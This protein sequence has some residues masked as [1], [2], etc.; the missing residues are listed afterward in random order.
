MKNTANKKSRPGSIGNGFS[1]NQN[2][3]A[4]GDIKGFDANYIAINEEKL[5]QQLFDH[6]A[7]HKKVRRLARCLGCNKPKSPLKFSIHSA[8]CRDCVKDLQMKGAVARSNFIERAKANVGR[9]L[10]GVANYA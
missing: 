7:Q 8:I 1:S 5:Q 4:D 3:Y 2:L 9:F 10:K 6:L